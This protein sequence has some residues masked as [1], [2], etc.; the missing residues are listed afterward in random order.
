[1]QHDAIKRIKYLTDYLNKCRNEY[2]NNSNS[3]ISD[4]EYDK[5]FDELKELEISENIIFTNSP[6][7]SVG[8][9]VT[10]ELNKVSHEL[11]PLLSLDKTQDIEKFKQFCYQNTVLLMPKLDGLTI[12]LEYKNGKLFRAS[13]RG[14]GIT[15][16]EITHNAKVFDNIPLT[17]PVQKDIIVIGEAIITKDVFD[18]I[19]SQLPENERFKNPRNLTSGSVKQLDSNIC[20]QRH[21]KF[22]C[23]QANDL[24]DT[25]LM[26]D[27]LA[28]ADQCGFETVVRYAIPT[29]ICTIDFDFIEDVIKAIK[30][31]TDFYNIP[32]DGIVASYDNIAF[33]KSLGRTAH[34]YNNGFAFKF[35]DEAITTT[36]TDI[37]WSIGKT[38]ELTPVAIFN[39]VEID[40]TTVT[41]ASLHNINTIEEM[42]LGINDCVEVYKANQIIPQIRKSL[43]KSNNV[44]IPDKCP[45]CNHNTEIISNISGEKIVKVLTCSNPQCKGKLL[46]SLSHYVSKPAMNIKGLSESTLDSLMSA[47][48]ISSILD[49]YNISEHKEQLISLERFGETSI[50]NLISAVEK[51]KHTTLPRL[52]NALSIPTVGKETAKLLS[53]YINNNPDNI[54]KLATDDLTAIEGIGEEMCNQIHEWFSIPDNANLINSLFKILVF[55]NIDNNITTDI[56]TNILNDKRFVITGKLIAYPNRTALEDVIIANGGKIQSSV[57][58]TTSYLINNDITSTSSKNKKAKNLNIPIISE[59]EFMK[60]LI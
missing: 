48:I 55:P 7:Q 10:G 26:R 22:I 11:Y 56:S 12:K 49:I 24:S 14:D 47:D 37:E 3:I 27:G 60:M 42:Q 29:D 41:R 50:N 31:N 33:G 34:H 28:I 53:E 4:Y 13:T 2:Y 43:T 25:G 52:I 38:G 58:A 40:G 51:S 54:F 9:E 36:L 17:I 32:I 5:L 57:S 23:W 15:G 39:P 30:T 8:Y 44:I 20:K 16:D 18:N 21:V 35:Y 19:N 59:S 46:K 45:V 1:M 6:T